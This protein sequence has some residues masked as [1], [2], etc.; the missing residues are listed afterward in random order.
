[1][2]CAEMESRAILN[3]SCRS[4]VVFI[5]SL[6]APGK[7]NWGQRYTSAMDLLFL[8]EF[9]LSKYL[10]ESYLAYCRTHIIT[11]QFKRLGFNFSFC[12]AGSYMWSG[13][14]LLISSQKTK[15]A[16]PEFLWQENSPCFTYRAKK[17][18]V[19]LFIPKACNLDMFISCR[20]VS[21]SYTLHW[22]PPVC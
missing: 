14:T 1:M 8:N 15:R 3:I 4:S 16:D 10:C 17:S 11:V 6:L 21:C 19:L 13:I 2:L 9:H 5:L 7:Y 20:F 18:P 12:R 22:A